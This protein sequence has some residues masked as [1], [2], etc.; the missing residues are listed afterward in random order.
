MEAA[1]L[2]GGL[3]AVIGRGAAIGAEDCGLQAARRR[4]SDMLP[5]MNRVKD[6]FG[7]II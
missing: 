2:V 3:A 7:F 5:L 6:L 1:G 4:I